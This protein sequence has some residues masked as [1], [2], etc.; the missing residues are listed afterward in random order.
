[1]AVNHL[2][3]ED[4]N[5]ITYCSA[6]L[7]GGAGG[8]GVGCGGERWNQQSGIILL[9]IFLNT[10]INPKHPKDTTVAPLAAPWILQLLDV[11]CLYFIIL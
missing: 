11:F 8:W 9:L 2:H 3:G 7:V 4:A 10:W 5:L 1:M 6:I